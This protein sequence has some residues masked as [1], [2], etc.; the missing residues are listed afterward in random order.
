MHN[1]S[2]VKKIPIS[3]T[4]TIKRNSPIRLRINA[5]Q[6]P[7]YNN[8]IVNV[9]S[10]MIPEESINSPI[11]PDRIKAQIS[12]LGNTPF[13]SLIHISEPTRP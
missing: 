13:L 1:G 2:E 8:I 3:C 12:K 5:N 10:D 11:D 7:F 9:E 6:P 4:I